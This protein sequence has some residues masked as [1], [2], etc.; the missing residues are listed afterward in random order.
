ML[1]KNLF[2][3]YAAVRRWLF[4]DNEL[5]IFALKKTKFIYYLSL[6]TFNHLYKNQRTYIMLQIVPSKKI[7][8]SVIAFSVLL[9]TGGIHAISSPLKNQVSSLS[10]EQTQ[11]S[12][13]DVSNTKASDSSCDIFIQ[14]NMADI[15]L[16]ENMNTVIDK[17]RKYAIK[18][19]LKYNFPKWKTAFLENHK[20]WLN[21]SRYFCLND[22]ECLLDKTR[23]RAETLK[24]KSVTSRIF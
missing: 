13:F 7:I 20:K 17:Q 16:Q 22:S 8:F 2:L 21:N 11:N 15:E 5:N 23:Q 19:G 24:K 14:Q 6:E 12:C 10:L 4:F 1:E 18:N 9:S 3:D